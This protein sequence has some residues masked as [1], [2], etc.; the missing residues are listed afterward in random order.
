MEDWYFFSVAALVLLGTQRFLYKVAAEKRCNSALTTAV[1]MATVTLLS[2][3]VYFASGDPAGNPVPLLVLALLNSSSFAFATIANIEALRH[4]P[5]GITFPLTRLSLVVVI[6]FSVL[7]FGERPQPLQWFG[8]LLVTAVVLLLGREAKS[9]VRID[10]NIRSGLLFVAVCVLCGALASISSKLAVASLGKAG[11]M[12]LS[13]LFA[14]CFSLAIEKQWG[15]GRAGGRGKQTLLLGMLMGVL[16]FFG[17]YA[18]LTALDGGPLAAVAT[19][20]GMH[21]VFAIVLS[22]LFYREPMTVRRSLGIVLTLL[23]VFFLKQ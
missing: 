20:T 21:F 4:L 14:T 11:F 16:N 6:L 15:Q 18:F 19:I 8:M 5:A 12:T 17:F 22:V 7:Y 13:Y 23:A 3:A 9:H 2:A 10:G 1:F